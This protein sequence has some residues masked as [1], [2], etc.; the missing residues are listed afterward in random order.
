MKAI[1]IRQPWA[2]AI[3]HAGKD[4]EN[5][6]WSTT[7]RGELA[8]HATQ[9]DLGWSFPVGVKHPP[10]RDMVLGAIVGLVEMVDVIRCSSSPWFTGPYGFLLRNPRALARP[11]ICP[12]NSGIWDL[13]KRL[14]HAIS[15]HA[16]NDGPALNEPRDGPCNS[17]VI[18]DL[19]AAMK[20]VTALADGRHPL[21]CNHPRVASA[22]RT[23]VGHLQTPQET[24][25]PN[26]APPQ[27]AGQSWTAAEEAELL[28]E[29]AAG[30]KIRELAKRHGRTDKSIRGRLYLLGK[31]PAWS[32]SR[33]RAEER[34]GVW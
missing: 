28:R 7:Y 31:L 24:L 34:N 17:P 3:L 5:R 8:V 21:T 20:I 30:V 14:E 12:G 23:I 13:P 29:F 15:T 18:M 19:G 32:P 22:L 25:K 4:I 6:S 26:L 27:K 33:Q 9:L 2:W 16:S 10:E 11:I 1:S